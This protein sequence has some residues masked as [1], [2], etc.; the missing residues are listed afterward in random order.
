VDRYQQ[1]VRVQSQQPYQL[2]TYT[3]C[4]A[5]PPKCS[6]YKIVMKTIFKTEVSPLQLELDHSVMLVTEVTLFITSLAVRDMVKRG[7]LGFMRMQTQDQIS[8]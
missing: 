5:L 8:L 6:R 1:S 2:R 3:W 7:Q 4:W